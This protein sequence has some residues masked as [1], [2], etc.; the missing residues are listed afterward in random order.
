MVAVPSEK[1]RV[2]VCSDIEPM[3]W[4]CR[5]NSVGCLL[6]SVTVTSLAA[7]PTTFPLPRENFG[8]AGYHFNIYILIGP[9]RNRLSKT[10]RQSTK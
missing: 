2:A 5:E 10:V 7:V 1:S 4:G 6:T 8:V 9:S 3:K